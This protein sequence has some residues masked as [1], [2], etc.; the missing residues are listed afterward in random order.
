MGGYHWSRIIAH[1]VLMVIFIVS[2]VLLPAIGLHFYLVF[3]RAK[4]FFDRH[5][6]PVLAAIYV[7]PLL[8]L[9]TFL[10]GYFTMR[11]LAWED[12]DPGKAALLA[13]VLETVRVEVY[14]C[15]AVAVVWGLT[16]LAC[17]VH[18]LVDARDATERNQVKWILYG[19]MASLI[20]FGYTLYLTFF[21]RY[22]FGGTGLTW[23]MFA[24][25]AIVSV[26]YAVSI[27]RYRLM[28]LDQ[29]ITSGAGYFLVSSL[30]GLVYYGVV[31]AG[32]ILASQWIVGPSLGQAVCVAGAALVLLLVVDWV[33]WRIRKALDRRFV[34][35][36]Q[37]IDR[38]LQRMSQ[39]IERLVDPPTLARRLLQESA[40]L[41][42]VPQG[43]VYLREARDVLVYR[44]AHHLGSPPP[45]TEL[46]PG[47]PVVEALKGGGTLLLRGQ[48]PAAKS[49]GF[50]PDPLTPDPATP[51]AGNSGCWAAS[52]PTAWPTRGSCWRC[53]CWG[54]ATP[55]RTGRRT[56]TSWPP[57]PR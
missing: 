57:S 37:N 30:A 53:W 3:P 19:L 9:G 54:R 44:L 25:S 43:A 48:E 56:S 46:S 21:Q 17:L 15:L 1:P 35:E 36:K 40:D 12:G 33:R 16:G 7:P 5:R 20:P 39:A 47:C 32:A 28:Q 11:E 6:R 45:L 34:R 55:G 31:L 27:T 2:S 29:L 14:V 50:L 42:G 22:D 13:W 38:T 24:A 49:Q 23:P 41:L 52:W 10:V 4:A 51:P 8:F 18:S 26:A